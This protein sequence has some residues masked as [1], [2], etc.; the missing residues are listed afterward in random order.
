M[1]QAF[2]Y[3]FGALSPVAAFIRQ[4]K[5]I[6]FILIAQAFPRIFAFSYF[7]P[8]FVCLLLRIIFRVV[9]FVFPLVDAACI[10]RI[11]DIH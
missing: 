10:E 2:F 3:A 11:P 5:G 7:I 9:F 4:C 8:R 6:Y 1:S